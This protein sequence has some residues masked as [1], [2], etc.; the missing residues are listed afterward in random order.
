MNDLPDRRADTIRLCRCQ[1][2]LRKPAR[3]LQLTAN[4]P[5]ER[6]M[7]LTQWL[8]GIL[9]LAGAGASA[10]T[11]IV[12]F[13]S[14]QFENSKLAGP[15]AAALTSKL[16]RPGWK[17]IDGSTIDREKSYLKL[18]EDI[19]EGNYTKRALSVDADIYITF[20]GHLARLKD[21]RTFML[22]V[23]AYEPLTAR[24][25]AS[26]TALSNPGPYET[27]EER[28]VLAM[29]AC[30]QIMPALSSQLE[31]TL[32]PDQQMGK[33]YNLV[34]YNPPKN[35]DMIMAMALKQTCRFVKPVRHEKRQDFYAQCK[36][37]RKEIIKV[38]KKVIRKK[39]RRKRYTILPAPR[40]LIVINFR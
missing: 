8:W 7:F 6:E 2:D 9:V 5:K 29:N 19:I 4:N 12:V 18:V 25:L 15:I 36:S 35:L 33:R 24:K 34:V 22:G 3:R 39:L 17:V 28:L 38:I 23:E 13:P 1:G 31:Q 11:T 27:L 21:M 40:Q 32:K 30:G 16:Q 14:E 26:E 37:P 20:E 10:E